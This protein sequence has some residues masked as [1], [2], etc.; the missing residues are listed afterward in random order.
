MPIL[1]PATLL[2]LGAVCA[3]VVVL[4]ALVVLVFAVF[5]PWRTRGG[6]Q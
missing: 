6:S 2:L 1:T 4:I 3:G 5:V